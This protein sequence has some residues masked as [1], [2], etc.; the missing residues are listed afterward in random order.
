METRTSTTHPLQIASLNIDGVGGQIGLTL[1]PG[2]KG[3]SAAGDYIWNRDLEADTR[4]VAEWGADLWLCL[5]EPNEMQ[6]AGV[7][8]L[9]AG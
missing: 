8:A 1:C 4:T 5:M 9:P 6:Q 3:P 2:K 7:A